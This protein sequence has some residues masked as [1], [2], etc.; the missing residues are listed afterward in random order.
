MLNRTRFS[1]ST[2][3]FHGRALPEKAHIVG[4]SAIIEA[5][6]LALPMPQ[7][8]A[9]ISEKHKVY[10]TVAWKVLTPRYQPEETLY[11]QLV[12][13]LKYEGV[14]LL[15]FKK[16]F[17][18]LPENA[19]VELLSIETTGQYT[20]K[21]WFL[22]EWLMQRQLPIADM[23]IKNYVSL[24]DTKLQY[25]LKDGERSARHRI[26]NN[27]PGTLHFCPLIRKTHTLEEYI[28]QDL[29]QQKDNYLKGIRKSILQKASAFLLLK[30]SRASFTIEGESPKS[31]RAARWG[32]AIG[33]AGRNNLS[34]GEFARLQQLV[35][36]DSR[37]TAMGYRS[38]GGF[39]GDRDT[40]TFSPIP[41][42]ISAK[43]QDIESLMN[44]LIATHKIVLS[45]AIDAV[46]AA[47]I[48]AFG[49]V[50]IHPFV[51]GNGRIHRYLIHHV[52]AQKQFSQ[53]G[54]IFPVSAAI[55]DKIMEYQKVLEAYSMPLLDFIEWE[56]STNH[57]VEVHNET[58]DYYRYFDATVQ[59]EFLYKCVKDTIENTI[60]QE[61]DYLNRYE[62]FKT[63]ID[64]AFEMPD[65]LL[66]LLVRFL[67][68]NKG[69]LS[70]R[71]RT[72]EFEAF[73]DD[74]VKAIEENF[75]LIFI[76]K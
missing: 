15:F 19:V 20:R 73:D 27:L 75:N 60:P 49:L 7:L 31:K 18:K 41:D 3:I 43:P 62:E 37:F 29:A 10:E 66:A 38:E 57:N 69:K 55:L 33:Q 4:Y 70:N 34:H 36:E 59:A 2:P 47:T 54:I 63:Y 6:Q 52:L 13:A 46:L 67:E 56:E 45:E 74:E 22:Y 11:H 28:Q 39:I 30:D 68:Q 51:D 25:A 61:V 58:I 8:I 71:A 9:L 50:F 65:D 26:I 17:E 14:H 32:Q 64:N 23:R 1:L 16:L 24:V 42:H 72:K 44:G 48:I 53:P 12:F 76:N 5:Y 40:D 35:I 21:L